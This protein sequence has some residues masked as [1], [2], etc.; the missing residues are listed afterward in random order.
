MG[1]QMYKS[2]FPFGTA[3]SAFKVVLHRTTIAE[4]GTPYPGDGDI[5]IPPIFAVHIFQ[6]INSDSDRLIFRQVTSPVEQLGWIVSCSTNEC[7][8][9]HVLLSLPSTM[10]C[11]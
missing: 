7:N 1:K 10:Y 2:C 11:F 6:E 5:L 9:T 3:Q 4:T 8:T